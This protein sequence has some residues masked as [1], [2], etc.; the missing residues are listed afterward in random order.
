MAGRVLVGSALVELTPRVSACFKAKNE[1]VPQ[2]K[3]SD[4]ENHTEWSEMDK[5]CVCAWGWTGTNCDE[6]DRDE[7][8]YPRKV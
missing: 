6:W 8:Y 2:F 5:T 3:P 1:D 4:C 7:C